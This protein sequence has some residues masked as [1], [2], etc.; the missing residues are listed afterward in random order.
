[1]QIINRKAVRQYD[2]F[3]RKKTKMARHKSDSKETMIKTSN[4]P[5]E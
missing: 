2:P 5:D 3:Q 4:I 1:M